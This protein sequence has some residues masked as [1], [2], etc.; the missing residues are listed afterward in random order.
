MSTELEKKVKEL[1]DLEKKYW[2]AKKAV[3]TLAH[4]IAVCTNPVVSMSDAGDAYILRA[5]SEDRKRKDKSTP[6]ITIVPIDHGTLVSYVV[7][8]FVLGD[9]Y[10]KELAT[11]DAL[12]PG[13]WDLFRETVALAAKVP[14]E[15][16]WPKPEDPTSTRVLEYS[17]RL[18]YL[19]IQVGFT[20]KPKL[21]WCFD[22]FDY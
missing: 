6:E 12:A 15:C 1:H 5:S 2:R 20:K 22:G 9:Q 14:K 7:K 11:R 18:R 8:E 4:K 13:R 17:M 3:D 21:V 16:N 19:P 10:R